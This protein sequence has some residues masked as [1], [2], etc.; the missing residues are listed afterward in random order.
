MVYHDQVNVYP[1][2]AAQIYRLLRCQYRD[3]NQNTF[4][5][6]DV[7]GG[8]VDAALFHVFQQKNGETTFIFK[9]SAVEP[10]GVYMLHRE[11][12]H[13]FLDQL[14]KKGLCPEIVNKLRDLIANNW[15]PDEVPD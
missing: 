14:S 2:I 11:R 4:M 15:M 5:L 6:V 13:W 7:G 12:I 1:E 3:P 9:A 10:L 8:T